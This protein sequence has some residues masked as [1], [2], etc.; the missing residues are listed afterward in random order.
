MTTDIRSLKY[1]IDAN[2]LSLD[3]TKTMF[4]SKKKKENLEN[5]ENVFIYL[6]YLA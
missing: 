2:Y 6:L 1:F 3:A 5:K 4:V